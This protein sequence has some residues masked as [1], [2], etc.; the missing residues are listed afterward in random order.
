[1]DKD[2]E[3]LKLNIDR[4]KEFEKKY[5][6]EEILVYGFTYIYR[7]KIFKSIKARKHKIRYTL[8]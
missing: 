3:E 8:G 4:L 2:K 6:D 5:K 1:M 7:L